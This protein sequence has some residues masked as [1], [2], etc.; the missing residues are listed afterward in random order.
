M[1]TPAFSSRSRLT[2]AIPPPGSGVACAAVRAAGSDGLAALHAGAERDPLSLMVNTQVACG[3]YMARRFAEADDACSL[4]LEMDPNFWP[5]RYFRG[6]TSEQQ[7]KFAQ[8]V[9]DLQAAVDGSGGNCLPRAALAHVHAQAGGQR[10]ARRILRQ[11]DRGTPPY[12][13]SWA[14]A[15]VYAGMEEAD[16]A[17]G[18][19]EDAI[20]RSSLQAGLFLKTDPRL[21]GLRSVPRFKSLEE[22]LYA[23]RPP[24]AARNASIAAAACAGRSTGISWP[25]SI[26]TSRA[27][28]IRAT[29]SCRRNSGE[30]IGSC[31]PASTSVPAV[32]AVT[33]SEKIVAAEHSECFPL[34][35]I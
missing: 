20:S 17:L 31:A 6:L 29:I 32:V 19:L 12:V 22:R 18:L 13:S 21:D 24:Q 28:G 23:E 15:L 11:L 34:G 14:L 5:A 25:Q 33:A 30:R 27:P 7:G 26:C 16:R 8:A 35:V 2:R 4:V 9:R 10:D 3:L 1:R